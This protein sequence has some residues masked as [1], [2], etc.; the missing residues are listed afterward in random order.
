MVIADSMSGVKGVELVLKHGRQHGE[1]L[2]R[3]Y[4]KAFPAI[5]N[6]DVQATRIVDSRVEIPRQYPNHTLHPAQRLRT[7]AQ[8]RRLDFN[9][10]LEEFVIAR[11]ALDAD[12][13]IASD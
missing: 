7:E 5:P 10:A 6:M 13:S 4:G 9:I 2:K 8:R 1:I 11:T 12:G 3:L